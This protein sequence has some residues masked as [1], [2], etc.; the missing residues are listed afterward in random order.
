[1]LRQLLREF[2]GIVD[3]PAVPPIDYELKIDAQV[4]KFFETK[5]KLTYFLVTAS[6]AVIAFIVTSVTDKLGNVGP[7]VWIVVLS[8]MAGLVAAGSSLLNLHCE[9]LS[10]RLHIKYRYQKKLWTNLTDKEQA[11]WDRLNGRAM[12]YL[13]VAFIFLFVEIVLGVVFFIG[14]FLLG[15]GQSLKGAII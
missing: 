1:M 9:L 6:A 12:R 3:P 7:L 5:Q 8:V 14:V 10:Y 13:K 4:E 11:Y 15:Y 2:L